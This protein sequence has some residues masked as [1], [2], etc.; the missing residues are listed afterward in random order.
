MNN[1]T[2]QNSVHSNTLQLILFALGFAL[3]I[4]MF[5]FSILM[6]VIVIV[7][8]LLALYLRS[9]L[10][11]LKEAIE[12]T[13]DS[14]TKLSHGDFEV[15]APEMGKAEIYN[16][17][18]EFNSMIKQLKHYMKETIKAIQVAEDTSSSYYADATGLNPALTQATQAINNS[19]KTI[20]DGYRAQ[21]RGNFSE[22]LHDLGGGISHSLTIIQQNLLNNSEEVDKISQMS[23]QT[24]QEANNSLETMQSVLGLFGD[25]SHKI[26]ATSNN[27]DSLSERSKEISAI[28]D[29]IKDI[30]EQTNLLALNAAIEAARAGE[31][32]RG[33]AVV[34][35][36]VRKLAERT[37]KSTQEISITIQTLQQETQEIQSNSQEIA[38]ISQNV[39]STIDDF[40]VTL[41]QFQTNAQGS[42][43]YARFI[44]DSLFMVLVKIDHILF[45]SNAYTSVLSHKV[46]AEFGDHRGCRLGKWYLSEGKE[47]Y[48]HTRNYAAIDA[49]HAKVHSNVIKNIE[50]MGQSTIF[51]TDIENIIIDNFKNMESESEKLFEILDL[52]VNELDPTKSGK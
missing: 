41:K 8:V 32:G 4:L 24:S 14:M 52:V 1:S 2:L 7:H 25:L 34:A 23:G 37:Q 36:E 40:A 42:A 31:H 20:E 13:T 28:A 3:E 30:A 49:P 5:D 44:R 22:K 46:N 35:D 33:F 29:I 38:D 43:E 50:L 19:V 39:T 26:E 18:V 6:I 27:I 51:E 21:V 45:K 9:Q 17:G 48:G 15:V 11:L 10:L 16:L 12:K 47:R